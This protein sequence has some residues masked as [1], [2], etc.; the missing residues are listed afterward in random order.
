LPGEQTVSYLCHNAR[1]FESASRQGP[2]ESHGGKRPCTYSGQA[3][4]FGNFG[5]AAAAYNAG[6]ARVADWLAGHSNLPAE[7]RGYVL[8]ISQ[9]PVEDWVGAEMADTTTDNETSCLQ[10]TGAIRQSEP[11]SVV[12]STLSAPWGVQL[13]GSFSRAAAI[14]AYRRAQ[15]SYS[16][17]LGKIEPMVIGGRVPSLGFASLLSGPCTCTLACG[18]GCTLSKDPPRRLRLCCPSEL[19]RFWSPWL[20]FDQDALSSTST[21]STRVNPFAM[22]PAHAVRIRTL[23]ICRRLRRFLLGV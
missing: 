11:H 22:N 12:G 16:A 1:S 4:R 7:T 21:P 8:A 9:H 17:I 20:R 15:S 13:A 5:L 14:A 23:I 2:A 10:L 3:E 19:T 18:S 6:P